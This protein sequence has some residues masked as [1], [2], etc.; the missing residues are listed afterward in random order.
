MNLLD[1]LNTPSPPK[2]DK[3]K[4]E[5]TPGRG[6][7][8]CKNCFKYI[9]VRSKICKF[10]KTSC[11]KEQVKLDFSKPKEYCYEHIRL[12]TKREKDQAEKI[13]K[14]EN[15]LTN[16]FYWAPVSWR[17][18]CKS[19]KDLLK[20]KDSFSLKSLEESTGFIIVKCEITN[21]TKISENKREGRLQ[22][23]KIIELCEIK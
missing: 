11:N 15:S 22:K 21:I 7:K 18:L 2:S 1:F 6:K 4:S 12:D 9:G 10:C 3:T 20:R 23:L 13:I 14:N 5:N 16:E 19:I 17:P 8:Q